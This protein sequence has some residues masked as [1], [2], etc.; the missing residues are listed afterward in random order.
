[1]Q[2]DFHHAVTYVV[3]RL[4]GFDHPQ[5]STVAYCAQYVDDA[6]NEG[7]IYFTTGQLYTRACSAHKM[8]DYRNFQELA[9][10]HVWIPFH[11][12]PGNDNG[13]ASDGQFYDKII[14][15]PDSPVARAMVAACVAQKNSAHALHRLGI[16]MHVY[17]DTW[18]H[19]G[20]AGISHEI[21]RVRQVQ[22]VDGNPDQNFKQ[23]LKN[24]FADLI[25]EASSQFVSDS[26]PLGHGAV[27]SYPDR[28]YLQWRYTDGRGERIERD[29]PRDFLVA[30][31]HLYQAMR[32]FNND[33]PMAAGVTIPE[34]DRSRI[35]S[36]LR[37]VVDA[38]GGA[39][40]RRWLQKIA[41]GAFSFGPQRLSYQ[42]SG[43][44]SWKFNAIGLRNPRA[45]DRELYHFSAN[46]MSSDW[47]R[48][49][50]A[51]L[52]HRQ[53]VLYDILPS[54]GICAA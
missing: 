17:A 48:F 29:N 5:A 41:E 36:L 3:A 21:N 52:A 1:M 12:L 46:F 45:D 14:C 40:H 25:D 11:F 37:S 32:W 38:D 13:T 20:F 42:P 24:F 16:A 43:E 28:P 15:R 26:L 18:A 34:P 53:S 10:H 31:D 27:L 7:T 4:A 8:L 22:D 39:R 35:D 49:H 44:D 9:N 19:Q 51:L 50:D 6:T 23:A 30:A 33:I 54:F 2:I 47:K